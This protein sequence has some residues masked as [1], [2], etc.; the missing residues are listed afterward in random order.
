[1]SVQRRAYRTSWERE[2]GETGSPIES[3]FLGAFCEVA[4]DNGYS[5][6]RKAVGNDVI[7]VQPQ[8][9]IDRYRLDFM[10]AFRFFGREIRLAIE[11][12]G[13][14]FHEKT[15]RQAA[16]DRSC[17][18]AISALGYQVVRFTGSEI[19]HDARACAYEALVRIMDFQTDRI[20]QARKEAA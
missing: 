5:I 18:R 19:H 15:K 10:I 17:E 11:C 2:L 6:R 1:M 8:K 13:H 14:E 7:A 9:T 4:F 12:D 3:D 16:K 20:E